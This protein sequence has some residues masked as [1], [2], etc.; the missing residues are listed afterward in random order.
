MKIYLIGHNAVAEGLEK[1]FEIVKFDEAEKVVLWQ[2][3]IE[4]G[5]GT[6]KYA[7]MKGKPVI[8]VQHGRHAYA[9]YGPPF[10]QTMISDVICAWGMNDKDRLMRF[11]IPEE[12]IRVTGTVV[13]KHLK[14]RKKH[15]GTNIIFSP[16]HWDY[17][18]EENDEVVRVLRKLR[19]V[20]I[21]TKIMNAHDRDKYD[22]P[23]YSH[24]DSPEHLQICA[25]A[26]REV[27]LMVAITEGTFELMAQILDIP[28]VVANIFK[29][30]TSLNDRRYLDYRH[31]W[32]DACKKTQDLSKLPGLIHY[33]LKHPEELRKERKLAAINDGGINIKDPLANIVKVIYD[34]HY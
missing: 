21:T 24:V 18:I 1:H 30:K 28:V 16:D 10:Y 5:R 32:S 34:T 12:K 27:D 14:P 4:E 19:G 6:A 33:H 20:K 7:H 8:Q 26:L 31:V 17:D 22:N 13:F 29:P 3:V 23:I 25:E 15:K 11:G 2:D 9:R